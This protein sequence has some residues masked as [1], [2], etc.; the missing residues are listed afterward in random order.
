MQHHPT[1]S[2]RP[3]VIP[4]TWQNPPSP[5]AE[6]LDNPGSPAVSISP[7]HRWLVEFW[8]SEL[9]P[10]EALAEPELGIAGFR[11]NPKT[12]TSARSNPYT[13]IAVGELLNDRENRTT[14]DLPDDAKLTNFKWSD[15]GNLLAFTWIKP[16]GLELWVLNAETKQARQVRSRKPWNQD[17]KPNLYSSSQEFSRR[18]SV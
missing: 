17:P 12:R 18:K 1:A 10:I 14:I 16:N 3:Q 7:N 6:I 11:I 5:I 4:T 9:V 15:S 8:R 2:D 13:K